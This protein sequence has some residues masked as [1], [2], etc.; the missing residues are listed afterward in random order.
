MAQAYQKKSFYETLTEA[1]KFFTEHGYEDESSLDLWVARIREA[2][3]DSMTP[4]SVMQQMLRDSLSAIYKR[5]IENGSIL[6]MHHGVSAFT[7]QK[8]KPKLRAELDRR[9][10][11]SANL[12]TLNREMMVDRTVQRFQG[13]ATSIPVGGT[14]VADKVEVK[15]GIR[16]ALAQ[17]PFE[18]RR[19]LIDQAHKFTA[20]LSNIIA[21]DGGAIAGKWHSHWRQVGYDYR[22]D[23]KERDGKVYAL[24]ASWA[25]DSG[26]VN[27]G[28]GYTD[29]MTKPGEEVFCR[30]NMSYLY[31]LRALPK[32]MI[33]QKGQ[34]DLARVRKELGFD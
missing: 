21:V 11:A 16:K 32:E 19:V 18:E 33:T 7:L 6:R 26:F 20:E 28:E 3:E 13:W 12:I 17:L 31:T 1:V 25:M 8:V 15:T 22:K 30:C 4:D 34:D 10:L 23:H 27:K 2:A 5:Q 24:R 29:E 14:K 9:I